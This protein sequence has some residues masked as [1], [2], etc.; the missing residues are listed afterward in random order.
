MRKSACYEPKL[1]AVLLLSLTAP[2]GPVLAQPF[3]GT[4]FLSPTVITD[5]DASSLRGVEYTGRG[6]RLIWDYRVFDWITINAYL[7]EARYDASVIEYQVNPEFGSEEAARAEVDTYAPAVG[8]LPAVLLSRARSVHVNAG[9]PDHPNAARWTVQQVFGGNF[10]DRSFTIHTGRGEEYI[11]G[12][13]LEEVLFHEGV[14]LSLQDHQDTADWLQAQQADGGFISDYARDNPATE[15]VAESALA[16]FV[17]RFR[18]DRLSAADRDEIAAAIPNRIA[19]FDDQG[20][21]WS[22]YMTAVPALPVPALLIGA[23]LLLV[24]RTRALAVR[25][26]RRHRAALRTLGC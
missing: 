24:A 15:D 22:P 11:A 17:V 6:E 16:Y 9:T 4:A 21:D 20:L 10:H 19:Y 12:G 2:A 26:G 7:F 13:F 25:V 5:A 23:A 8:R 18:P 3:Q 14:H 1:T